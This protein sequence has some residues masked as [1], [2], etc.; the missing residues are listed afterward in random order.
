MK[1]QVPRMAE[2]RSDYARACGEDFHGPGDGLAAAERLCS[3]RIGAGKLAAAGFTHG[4]FPCAMDNASGGNSPPQRRQ[5]RMLILRQ[6]LIAY[7]R[8]RQA[9]LSCYPRRDQG[10]VAPLT[11]ARL[12]VADRGL[13]SQGTRGREQ[14]PES[15]RFPGFLP[16]P[17]LKTRRKPR[18]TR[19]R[20]S[21]VP[22]VVMCMPHRHVP[23]CHRAT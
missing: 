18:H 9:R 21:F 5:Q 12:F 14:C 2:H 4:A 22:S 17:P 6:V 7:L 23:A 13:R 1:I 16:R 11:R 19:T 8:H 20:I 15:R 10:A 3:R